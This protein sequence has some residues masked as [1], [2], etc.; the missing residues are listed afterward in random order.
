MPLRRS[1]RDGDEQRRTS[2]GEAHVVVGA[3]VGE[4]EA[5]QRRPT[6]RHRGRVAVAEQRSAVQVLLG[7]DGEHER[8]DGEAADPRTRSAPTP[9]ARRAQRSAIAATSIDARNGSGAACTST[10]HTSSSSPRFNA[11]ASSAPRPAN[12]ICASDSW[13]AQPVMHGHRQRAD[14]EADDA[15]VEQLATR[16]GHHDGQHDRGEQSDGADDPREVAG[17][18]RSAGTRR[19]SGR[20]TLGVNANASSSARVRLCSEDR[21]QRPSRNPRKSARPGWREVL[22]RSTASPTPITT[23]NSTARRERA[24]AREHERQHRPGQRQ[25]SEVAD[26]AGAAGLRSTAA[27]STPSTSSPATI[28]TNGRHELGVDA[29]Q[30][31]ERGGCRPTP[32]P[33]CR[34]AC[35]AGA[36]SARRRAAGRP[37]RWSAASR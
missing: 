17:P 23:P 35:G 27:P 26:A 36:T 34:A 9:M 6:E 4:V 19:G 22:K 15:A 20:R 24:H 33:P 18:T 7:G 12:A 30:A 5:E 31:G 14:G 21:D 25:R 16:P 8:R 29:G 13:P 28:H 3:L 10:S 37:P 2:D 32:R 11:A 1:R